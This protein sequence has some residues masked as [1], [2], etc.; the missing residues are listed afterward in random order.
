MNYR[1][2]SLYQNYSIEHTAKQAKTIQKWKQWITEMYWNEIKYC[3]LSVKARE[4]AVTRNRDSMMNWALENRSII[5]I[6]KSKSTNILH[7]NNNNNNP[8]PYYAEKLRDKFSRKTNSPSP[9]PYRMS[10]FYYGLQEMQAYVAFRI[11]RVSP[12]FG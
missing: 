8:P 6:E 1:N 3:C 4:I 10:C 7:N 9:S 5:C 2:W 12:M 11:N